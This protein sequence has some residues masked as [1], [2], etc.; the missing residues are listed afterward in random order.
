MT[1]I[2]II[3]QLKALNQPEL[4]QIVI[5]GIARLHSISLIPFERLIANSDKQHAD[6]SLAKD[7]FSNLNV[8]TE[9][10]SSAWN[11]YNVKLAFKLAKN[12]LFKNNEEMD[13]IEN[14]EN[15]DKSANM[16]RDF[17]LR[18]VGASKF[19]DDQQRW[20]M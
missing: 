3:V 18:F 20:V 9:N 17:T 1:L 5:T 14:I 10:C 4:I 8:T 13:K 11:F 2:A 12:V 7:K 6:H 15:V 16:Y 19:F